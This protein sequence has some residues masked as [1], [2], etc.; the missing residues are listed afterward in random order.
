[1]NSVSQIFMRF[2]CTTLVLFTIFINLNAQCADNAQLAQNKKCL[3]LTWNVAPPSIPTTVEISGS[4]YN[5][6]SFT[7]TSAD[8]VKSGSNTNGCNMEGHN[9]EI[10]IGSNLC[11][12]SNGVL[13]GS[14]PL[15]VTLKEFRVSLIENMAQLNW[16]TESELNNEGF[17]LEKSNNGFYWKKIGW[18]KGA[19]TSNN[20]NEYHFVD[21][22]LLPGYNYYRLKQMDFDGS[23]NYSH[24]I[25]INVKLNGQQDFGVFPNPAHQIISFSNLDWEYVQEINI[26][27]QL[28]KAVLHV[29]NYSETIDI[30]DLNRGVYY[31]V[32]IVNNQKLTKKLMVH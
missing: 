20:L 6:T 11:T 3:T 8:Y 17:E 23:F 26:Y 5:R 29:L 16:A 14:S 19:G 10:T 21:N 22:D 25:S 4:T 24:I 13:A 27:N 31:V 18:E 12:Y 1:M 30:V 15:P 2:A 9:G 7:A 32:A 28:G